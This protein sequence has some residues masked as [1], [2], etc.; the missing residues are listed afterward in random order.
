MFGKQKQETASDASSAAHPG[1]TVMQDDLDTLSGKTVSDIRPPEADV[2]SPSDSPFLSASP[3]DIASPRERLVV[4]DR[5]VE[6]AESDILAMWKK[7][8][9]A[10]DLRPDTESMPI[11]DSKVPEIGSLGK[12]RLIIPIL[13]IIVAAL[14]IGGAGYI[15]F[16]GRQDT[17]TAP[18]E[19]APVTK[20]V[21]EPVSEAPSQTT[22]FQKGMP[23]YLTIDV[24]SSDSTPE[25][26]ARLIAETEDEVSSEAPLFPVEFLIRDAN[27]NP[28]AFARFA[29]L[30]GMRVPEETLSVFDEGFSLFFV[31]DTAGMNRV[32]VVDTREGSDVMGAMRSGESSAVSWFASALYGKPVSV[33]DS[34]PFVSGS[35]GTLET[36]Y[37]NIDIEHDVSFDYAVY[38]NAFIVGSS[39]NAFRAVLASVIGS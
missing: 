19:T 3:Q 36:R 9:P 4:S 29:Y 28:V 22:R 17:A 35:F 18:V 23:N 15:F 1:V 11:A 24:E 32:L 2:A 31:P 13:A 33:S 25:A 14:V 8:A 7:D 16:F 10:D 37:L 6:P 38:G 21:G 39:K 30:L 26:L 12:N 27:N 20:P 34:G 5:P